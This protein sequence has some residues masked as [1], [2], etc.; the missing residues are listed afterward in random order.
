VL[1]KLMAFQIEQMKSW[2]LL[3]AYFQS[4]EVD[5]AYVMSTLAMDM[6][7]EKSHFRWI[8]LMHRDGN[9]LAIA[10][11]PPKALAFIK[12]RRNRARPAAFEQFL[13][14]ADLVETGGYGHVAWY[15]KDVMLWPNCHVDCI[16][17]ATAKAIK[18][19][20][21][22]VKEVMIYVRRAGEDIEK[23]R[24]VGDKKLESIVRVVRKH[25]PAHTCSPIIASL[26]PKLRVVNY[27]PLNIDK[28]GL[29]QIMDLEVEGGILKQGIDIDTFSDTHFS[30]AIPQ[31]K[32]KAKQQQYTNCIGVK[33]GD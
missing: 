3:R 8:G 15:S 22:A 11:P 7:R 25:I 1:V 12:A 29:K 30:I 23:A 16:A 6:Y 32:S 2:D 19:R 4:G 31:Q 33:Q 26:D 13:P 14:W 24:K 18:H 17:L 5:M 10:V 9:A 21:S 20:F 28:D 27:Q